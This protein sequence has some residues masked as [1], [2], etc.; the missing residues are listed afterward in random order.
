MAV[1]T[2]AGAL[3]LYLT[4]AVDSVVT[5]GQGNCLILCSS[6]LYLWVG[7]GLRPCLRADHES[8]DRT[9]ALCFPSTLPKQNWVC[10][11]AMLVR[12]VVLFLGREQSCF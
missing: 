3:P 10:G 8:L 12:G 11:L 4:G 5:G 6:H 9:H 7:D 2:R 1:T